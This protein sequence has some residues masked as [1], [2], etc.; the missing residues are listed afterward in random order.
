MDPVSL[1]NQYLTEDS[2]FFSVTMAATDT[3]CTD[4]NPLVAVQTTRKEA[5]NK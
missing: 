1:R 5:Q 3:T 2:S 4:G